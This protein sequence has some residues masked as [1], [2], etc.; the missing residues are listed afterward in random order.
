MKSGFKYWQRRERR[1]AGNCT[2]YNGRAGVRGRSESAP[3]FC[4]RMLTALLVSLGS[5]YSRHTHKQTN[6]HTNTGT[7]RDRKVSN[8]VA[9]PA[10]VGV[11]LVQTNG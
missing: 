10:A 4:R 1:N 11:A 8:A 5:H 3:I 2:R 9:Q 7:C 6:R